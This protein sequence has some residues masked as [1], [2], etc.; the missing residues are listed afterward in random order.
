MGQTR[1]SPR[2]HPCTCGGGDRGCAHVRGGCG[3]VGAA[4]GSEGGRLARTVLGAL[5]AAGANNAGWRDALNVEAGRAR[6][7]ERLGSGHPNLD[8]GRGRRLCCLQS[9]R[10]RDW[11]QVGPRVGFPGRQDHVGADQADSRA[12]KHARGVRGPRH[13]QRAS[14]RTLAMRSGPAAASAALPRGRPTPARDRQQELPSE[15]G[16]L[17]LPPAGTA[18][19]P[20]DAQPVVTTA[21]RAV[22]PL[23]PL[24]ARGTRAGA[25]GRW[26]THRSRGGGACA[27]AR[28]LAWRPACA[29]ASSIGK[30]PRSLPP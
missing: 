11:R 27:R 7:P 18:E 30:R 17:W 25:C 19:P 29:M 21:G 5:S 16:L 15:S 13:A 24:A 23:P 14:G 9:P 3:A 20:A 12:H 4:A 1:A 22:A 26:R 6:A 10:S 8:R 2:F 28:A